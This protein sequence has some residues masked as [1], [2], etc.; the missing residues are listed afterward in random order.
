MAPAGG[1]RGAARQPGG[2]ARHRG[3]LARP[4]RGRLPGGHGVLAGQGRPGQGRDRQ[5]LDRAARLAGPH[6]PRRRAVRRVGRPG[7]RR[8]GRLPRGLLPALRRRGPRPSAALPLEQQRRDGGGVLAAGRLLLRGRGAGHPA[9]L[10]GRVALRRRT[11]RGQR[12]HRA[13]HRQPRLLPPGHRPA[14]RRATRPGLRLPAHLAHPPG[15]LLRRRDRH[16]LPA[17]SAGHRGQRARAA[18]QPGRFAHA[19]AVGAGPGGRILQ[20]AARAAVPAGGPGP[21]PPGRA[22]P[23]RRP[24]LAAAHRPAV[25][26]PAQGAPGAGLRRRG[27]GPARRVPAGVHPVSYTHL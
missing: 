7:R 25:D 9:A 12:A 24:D 2:A 20:R 1:R 6:P 4:R 17:R 19:D 26:R 16:A 22:L 5:A 13:A 23:A 18:L 10:P 15:G 8:R 21:A 11:R 27:G 3:A 14:H